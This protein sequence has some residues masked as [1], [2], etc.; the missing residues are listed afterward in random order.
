M[1]CTI[2]MNIELISNNTEPT[3]KRFAHAIPIFNPQSHSKIQSKLVT[4]RKVKTPRKCP[5]QTRSSG[6][7]QKSPCPINA[8]PTIPCFIEPNEFHQSQTPHRPSPF[9]HWHPWVH[10][11]QILRPRHRPTPIR[12]PTPTRPRTITSSM[13]PLPQVLTA[14]SRARL[15]TINLALNAPLSEAEVTLVFFA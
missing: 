4:R 13:L 12:T 6:I 9:M 15:A 8:S 14:L 10:I 5:S 2:L 11:E 3:A 1:Q 7:S